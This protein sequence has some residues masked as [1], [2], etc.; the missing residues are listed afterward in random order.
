MDGR[1]CFVKILYRDACSHAVFAT[2]YLPGEDDEVSAWD[3]PEYG[4]HCLMFACYDVFDRTFSLIQLQ[5]CL[6]AG[7]AIPNPPN[8]RRDRTNWCTFG[9][10]CYTFKQRTR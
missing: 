2:R 7:S 10:K 8:N 6:S 5:G 9:K 4:N 1:Y 3:T